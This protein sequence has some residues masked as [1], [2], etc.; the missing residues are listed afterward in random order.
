ERMSEEA[1]WITFASGGN[2]LKDRPVV[3]ANGNQ[4]GVITDVYYEQETGTQLLGFELSDGFISDLK[5]GRRWLRI[6]EEATIGVD[7]VVVSADYE[8]KLEEII[9]LNN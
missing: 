7:A 8:N 2:K 6:S 5:D 1:E 3:T 4:L 9:T